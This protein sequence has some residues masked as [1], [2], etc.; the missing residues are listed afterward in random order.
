MIEVR[1]VERCG[2]RE[3]EE[4]IDGRSFAAAWRRDRAGLALA[5]W[6]VAVNALVAV[7]LLLGAAAAMAWRWIGGG[8]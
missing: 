7:A 1:K 8:E 6:V 5:A 3:Q 2:E 4:A